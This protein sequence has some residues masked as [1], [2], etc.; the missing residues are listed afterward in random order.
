MIFNVETD[1]ISISK[2]W[3][4][5]WKKMNRTVTRKGWSLLRPSLLTNRACWNTTVVELTVWLTFVNFF[6]IWRLLT[7]EARDSVEKILEN[8]EIVFQ[9]CTNIFRL[10]GLNID[11][12][13]YLYPNVSVLF[14]FFKFRICSI[15]LIVMMIF[16]KYFDG[17]NFFK[18]KNIC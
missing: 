1:Q 4:W 7:D 10:R 6:M 16:D 13:F 2:R 18:F 15:V 9:F 8:G 11:F 14:N 5:M 12:F 17:K 3:I